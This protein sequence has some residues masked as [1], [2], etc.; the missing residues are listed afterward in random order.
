MHA[1]RNH[2]RHAVT[3]GRRTV[4]ARKVYYRPAPERA[5]PLDERRELM[6]QRGK[7]QPRRDVANVRQERHALASARAKCVETKP[8]TRV[9]ARL[10]SHAR[11]RA[12]RLG[13]FR[14]T[15]RSVYAATV[16]DASD[17]EPRVL[18]RAP[19]VARARASETMRVLV[20]VRRP[21]LARVCV[22]SRAS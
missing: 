4:L 10:A 20:F 2:A 16:R 11:S 15:T 12:P 18:S 14:E 19:P 8:F 5:Q 7:M 3:L 22:R 21:S 9:R 17:R 13:R 6:R 1:L